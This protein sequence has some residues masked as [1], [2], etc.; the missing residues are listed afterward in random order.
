MMNDRQ[1]IVHLI[2]RGRLRYEPSL[3]LFR[4]SMALKRSI[5][6]SAVGACVVVVSA[7]LAG[8]ATATPDDPL[9]DPA[10]AQIMADQERMNAWI[11]TVVGPDYEGGSGRKGLGGVTMDPKAK[12]ITLSWKGALPSVVQ[13]AVDNPPAGVAVSV[14]SASYTRAEMHKARD[15]FVAKAARAKKETGQQWTEISPSAAGAGLSIEVTADSDP[16]SATATLPATARNSTEAAGMPVDVKLGAPAEGT[17]GQ[18]WAA[19]APWQ[20]GMAMRIPS[21]GMCSSAFTGIGSDGSKLILTAA[22]C[23]TSGD[24]YSQG[25]GKIGRIYGS[26]WNRDTAIIGTGGAI[27]ANINDG[28][29]NAPASDVRV[30]GRAGYNYNGNSVCT[31]GAM[32]GVHCLLVIDNDDTSFYSKDMNADIAPAIKIR[33]T[34]SGANAMIFSTGDSGGPAFALYDSSNRREARGIISHGTNVVGCTTTIAWS[35]QTCFSTGYY[36]AIKRAI[37]DYSMTLKTG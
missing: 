24:V 28:R 37:A 29:W 20:A 21:G 11:D 1:K 30:T 33:A 27:S 36:V 34:G 9:S 6:V 17:A 15:R 31:S 10:L 25:G 19:T 4:G 35:G 32:S 8:P 13:K 26:L 7:G 16:A 23:G 12:T 5:F 18:R 3:P 2:T 14:I 22:H